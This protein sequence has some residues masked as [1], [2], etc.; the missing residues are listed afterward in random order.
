ML[1]L[2]QAMQ[3]PTATKKEKKEYTPPRFRLR[4]KGAVVVT[5][6]LLQKCR[7]AD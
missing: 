2:V 7:L 5:S 4:E 6:F 3:S 1:D